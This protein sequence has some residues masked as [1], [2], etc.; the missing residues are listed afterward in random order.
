MNSSPR[1][2]RER[3]PSVVTS[4]WNLCGADPSL[5]IADLAK[6]NPHLRDAEILELAFDQLL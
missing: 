3:Y 6:N 1:S 5:Y 2:W 4:L